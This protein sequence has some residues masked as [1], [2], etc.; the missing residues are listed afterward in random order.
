MAA[1]E[2]DPVILSKKIADQHPSILEQ[3]PVI[4]SKK[5]PDQHPSVLEQS[6][7]EKH[8]E[9]RSWLSKIPSWLLP[10]SRECSRICIHCGIELLESAM[11]Q[12]LDD[13]QTVNARFTRPDGIATS[14]SYVGSNKNAARLATTTYPND[15]NKLMHHQKEIHFERDRS[16]I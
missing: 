2:Q 10:G 14:V 15:S 8:S 7:Q 6:S 13:C 3:D 12:H 4:L 9:K 1:I 5:V 16:N 11:M